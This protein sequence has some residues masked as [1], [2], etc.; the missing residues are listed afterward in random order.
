MLFMISTSQKIHREILNLKITST[1]VSIRLSKTLFSLITYQV[2]GI[3]EL[4]SS[5]HLDTMRN[6]CLIL[7]PLRKLL[8][9]QK[10]VISYLLL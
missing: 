5:I 1:K 10:C 9:I 8:L 6:K 2:L 3:I 7:F 4:A